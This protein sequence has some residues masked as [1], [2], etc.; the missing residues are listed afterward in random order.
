[1]VLIAQERHSIEWRRQLEVEIFLKTQK[2]IKIQTIN[3]EEI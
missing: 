1:M 3:C 2:S